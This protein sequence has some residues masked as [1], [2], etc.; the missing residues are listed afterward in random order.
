MIPVAPWLTT[1]LEALDRW[2]TIIAGLIAL[3]AAIIGACRPA[4]M[5]PSWPLAR[6]RLIPD[7]S[8][9]SV[10]ASRACP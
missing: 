5:T 9:F 4:R 7:T 1:L 10:P 2:Q 6:D 3:I 8:D